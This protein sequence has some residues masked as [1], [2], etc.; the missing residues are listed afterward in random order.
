M[1]ELGTLSKWMCRLTSKEIYYIKIRRPQDRLICSKEVHIHSMHLNTS[2][3]YSR[4]WNAFNCG[5]CFIVDAQKVSKHYSTLFW[6]VGNGP[7][8]LCWEAPHIMFAMVL[9]PVAYVIWTI[10]GEC[11]FKALK[12]RS[13]IR[14]EPTGRLCEKTTT[15][16]NLLT[17]DCKMMS[18]T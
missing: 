13:P 6:Y 17:A 16:T 5:K 15:I 10:I 9:V 4:C 8:C 18:Q 14:K 1:H 7:R 12:I 3:T 11:V 2:S